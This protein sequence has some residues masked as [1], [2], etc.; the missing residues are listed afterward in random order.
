MAFQTVAFCLTALCHR[1][2]VVED[3]N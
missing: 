1:F 2:A 3:D